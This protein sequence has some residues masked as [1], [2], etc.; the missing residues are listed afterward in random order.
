MAGAA[1]GRRASFAE[2]LAGR[3]ALFRKRLALF[4]RNAAE[5]WQI[6]SASRLAILGL[7]LVVLFGL[8][9]VSHPIMMATVWEGEQTMYDPRTGFDPMIY[10]HPSPPSANHLLGTDIQGHDVLSML[11]AATPSSFIVAIT[12]AF[13]AVVIGT[14]IGAA[15]AYYGGGLFDKLAGYV[16][17]LLLTMPAPI[18][19]VIIGARFPEEIDALQFGLIYGVMAGASSMA[20]VMRSQA[21]KLMVMPFVEA[22]R[23][24][25]AGGARIILGHL[26]PNMMPLAITQMMLTVAGAATSWGFI[27]FVG[28][29][30]FRLNWGSMIYL[31]LNFRDFGLSFDVPWSQLLA[32]GIALSL[33]AASFY[34]ISRGLHNIA[35]PRLRAR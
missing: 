9:A 23:A 22:S 27:A 2:I 15:S 10:P 30:E 26:V 17:G 16:A 4:R 25:G 14:L 7:V 5:T 13:T 29:A 12:A 18:L 28:V 35:E 11:L 19:L 6:Y 1:G 32:P 8:M 31:A 21:L 34:F 24:A 20:I 33:F 3:W